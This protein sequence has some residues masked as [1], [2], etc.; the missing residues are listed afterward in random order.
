MNIVGFRCHGLIK[1]VQVLGKA[2]RLFKLLLGLLKLLPFVEE[3][4]E[5][6]ALLD[7]LNAGDLASILQVQQILR[8]HQ[9]LKRVLAGV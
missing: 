6:F 2:Q 4:A 3:F 9:I 5:S 7:A 8:A 1:R